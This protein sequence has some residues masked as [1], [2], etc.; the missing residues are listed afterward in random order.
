M[1][2][3]TNEVIKIE[4]Y[5]DEIAIEIIN[6]KIADELKNKTSKSYKEL[7]EKISVLKQYKKE[8]YNNNQEVIDKIVN[9]Y[10]KE[11]KQ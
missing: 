1:K 3:I 6:L 5:K 11:I 9:E 10:Q 7:K 2:N 8:I 4:E